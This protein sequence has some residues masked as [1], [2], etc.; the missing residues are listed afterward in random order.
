MPKTLADEIQDV[1]VQLKKD[2]SKTQDLK[3]LIDSKRVLDSLWK[4]FHQGN[5]ETLEILNGTASDHV[6][7]KQQYYEKIKNIKNKCIDTIENLVVSFEN[8]TMQIS[9]EHTTLIRLLV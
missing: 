5:E 8:T 2:P 3:H 1:V 4:R 6:Y 9:A 7:V